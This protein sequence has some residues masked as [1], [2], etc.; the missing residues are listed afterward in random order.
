MYESG[1]AENGNYTHMCARE[2]ILFT[3]Y[4]RPHTTGRREQA[5]FKVKSILKG[6]EYELSKQEP[7]DWLQQQIAEQKCI[8]PLS[9]I[10]TK[11]TK[12]APTTSSDLQPSL[13]VDAKK[14][15][16]HM[17]QLFMDQVYRWLYSLGNRLCILGP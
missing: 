11:L 9:N 10:P 17:K 13:P 16:K 12:E 7:V 6:T 8:D 5:A 4:P 15:C 3:V 1:L 14:Q 2:G